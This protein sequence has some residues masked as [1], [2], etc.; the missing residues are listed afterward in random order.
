MSD[1]DQALIAELVLEY[2]NWL[3]DNGGISSDDLLSRPLTNTQRREL[4]ARMED[5]NVV[6]AATAPIHRALGTKPPPLYR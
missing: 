5:V 6:F 1:D 2:Y 3:T 4:L